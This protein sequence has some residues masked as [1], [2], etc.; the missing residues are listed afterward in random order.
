MDCH[1][2]AMV[3][4]GASANFQGAKIILKSFKFS[5]T[6]II[7]IIMLKIKMHN[8]KLTYLKYAILQSLKFTCDT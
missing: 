1:S 2:M 4:Q 6:D 7:L 8:I 3:N 5:Y